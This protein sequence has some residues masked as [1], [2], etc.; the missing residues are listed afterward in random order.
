M[1]RDYRIL[2]CVFYVLT[3]LKLKLFLLQMANSLIQQAQQFKIMVEQV[4]QQSMAYKEA[5][6]SQ[7]RQQMEKVNTISPPILEK[8]DFLFSLWENVTLSFS[9]RFV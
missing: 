7:V 9:E 8:P 1:F 5:A 6:V 2:Q 3:L 4:K